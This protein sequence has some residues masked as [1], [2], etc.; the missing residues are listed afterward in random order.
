MRALRAGWPGSSPT[1]PPG[2]AWSRPHLPATRPG[3]APPRRTASPGE[4]PATLCG[5]LRE[6]RFGP[7]AI[8][9]GPTLRH[10]QRAR[11]RSRL[12]HPGPGGKGKGLAPMP[13]GFCVGGQSSM[14][15][16]DIGEGSSL[17]PPPRAPPRARGETSS[18]H[19]R[20]R[21]RTA[22]LRLNALRLQRLTGWRIP[23]NEERN[24]KTGKTRGKNKS[25]RRKDET[26]EDLPEHL[27]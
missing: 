15:G 8:A 14:N 11:S 18:T 9:A 4:Y 21:H 17:P 24:H 22:A 3:L 1:T 20:R 26:A 25:R 19:H 7:G 6:T 5:P 12:R 10:A 13:D 16:Q 27:I 23:H 2:P